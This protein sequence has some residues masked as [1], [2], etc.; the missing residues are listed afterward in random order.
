MNKRIFT[1][2]YGPHTFSKTEIDL[3]Y[4][5]SNKSKHFTKL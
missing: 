4:G 1:A 5:E 2:M 3:M